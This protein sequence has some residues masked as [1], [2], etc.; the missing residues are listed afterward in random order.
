MIVRR[1]LLLIALI[2]VSMFLPFTSAQF[3]TISV[4]GSITV[5]KG[6]YSSGTLLLTNN[7]GVVYSVVSYQSFWVEDSNGNRVEGFNFTMF[8]RVFPNWGRGQNKTVKY[9]LTVS[10]DVLPGN[11]TLY[12]RFI[13]T[14][15]G[16]VYILKAKVPVEVLASPLTFTSAYSYVPGRGD[17]PYVFLGESVTVYS[18]VINIGHFNVTV[19]VFSALR[20]G[21]RDYS[22]VSKNVTISP[23][24][25]L[26]RL[27]LPVGWDYPEG[28]Y[29]LIYRVSYGN[30][31]YTYTKKLTVSLGVRLVGVSVEKESVL[32]NDTLKAYVTLIS[33]RK[34]NA[35]ISCV[36]VVNG[37]KPFA[38]KTKEVALSPGTSVVQLS[39]PTSEPGN[40][41]AV[42]GLS[43]HGRSGG[44]D[45]VHYTVYAPPSIGSLSAKLLNSTLEVNA[46][47]L[48][49][50]PETVSGTLEYRV[51]ANGTS[52]YSDVL[53]V[54]IPPGKKELSFKFNVPKG[55][56]VTYSFKLNALGRV[57]VKEGSLWVPAP[58]PKPSPSATSSATTVPESNTTSTTGGTGNGGFPWWPVVVILII[59]AVALVFYYQNQP[60][61]RRTRKAPKRRSPL[62]RF[63]R[64]KPPKFHERD[65][66]PK[67]K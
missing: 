19:N 60:K 10:D 25:T 17:V 58:K 29:T 37:T 36:A 40:V 18:H 22:V 20:S 3:G 8:P 43:V 42:I 65:S 34:I 53:D 32:L 24:D 26:I 63:K 1:A 7:A 47:L 62:G 15:S 12:L 49:P 38:T 30:Q 56:N 57:S 67:K 27:S 2:L 4:T 55:V 51:L 50:T 33:E 16:D 9:N 5:V 21:D 23:G 6:D 59:V 11:Y 48:N 54:T 35:T 39:L 61:K 28:N 44:N 46:L 52:L 45:T 64:P 31:E 14:Y 66:L 41:S 13:A